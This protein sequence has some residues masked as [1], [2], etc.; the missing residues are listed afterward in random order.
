MYLFTDVLNLPKIFNPSGL[1]YNLLS[2]LHSTVTS[3]LGGQ[4]QGAAAFHPTPHLPCTSPSPSPS[5]LQHH[6]QSWW[7]SKSAQPY[8]NAVTV[9]AE[10]PDPPTGIITRILASPHVNMRQRKRQQQFF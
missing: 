9:G 10:R 1:K 2:H 3:R 8:K 7:Q 6:T 4:R 5:E